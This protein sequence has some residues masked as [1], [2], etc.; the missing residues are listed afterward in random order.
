MLQEITDSINRNTVY[1]E[2]ELFHFIHSMW[3][4]GNQKPLGL[5]KVLSVYFTKTGLNGSEER[6]YVCE[7]LEVYGATNIKVGDDDVKLAYPQM[8]KIFRKDKL[9]LI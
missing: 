7:V 4:K 6:K 9:E 1:E 5:G 8:K 2:G 3:G